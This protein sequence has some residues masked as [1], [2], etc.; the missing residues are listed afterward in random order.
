MRK[1]DKRVRQKIFFFNYL[2]F[3][4]S[5][6]NNEAPAAPRRPGPIDVDRPRAAQI[7]NRRRYNPAREYD[8]GLHNPV[9]EDDGK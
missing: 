2:E 8:D 9:I 7:R 1:D 5:E 4:N 3:V 6:Q